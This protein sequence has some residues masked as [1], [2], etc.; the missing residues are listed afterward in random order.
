MNIS[1]FFNRL[2]DWHTSA[3]KN[4][5]PKSR[6]SE[7]VKKDPSFGT[8]RLSNLYSPNFIHASEIIYGGQGMI[9]QGGFHSVDVM[10]NKVDLLGKKILDIG[11]GL[12]GMDI[13]LAKKYPLEIVGVDKEP[14]MTEKA[15]ELLL[16]EP[17]SLKGR[18]SFLNL[19]SPLKLTEFSDNTF[20]IVTSKEMLYHVPNDAKLSYINE[21]FR[22]L[23]PG[24][25]VVI[26]D[27]HSDTPQIGEHIKRA[28]RVD[29]FC[30]FVTPLNFK[31]MLENAL[32]KDISYTDVSDDH[33]DYTRHDIKRMNEEA[34]SICNAASKQ[35]LEHV[36]KSWDLFLQA[37][38]SREWKASIFV[39][40]KPLTSTKQGH[41]N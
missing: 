37:L 39:A 3:E 21:M 29:G 23:K 2:C 24:G 20:D 15:E 31:T 7:T 36:R 34:E 30:H 11:C 25:Q 17:K 12:G 13:Y 16:K 26:A 22:V 5:I 27:W 4:N 38:E 1:V 9:S 35:T 40:S 19:K 8:T 6:N 32:F 18:V 10:F 28:V 41:F 14:Y 33:I